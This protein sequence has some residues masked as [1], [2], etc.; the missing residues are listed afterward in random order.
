MP[1]CPRMAVGIR[2]PEEPSEE[3]CDSG[4]VRGEWHRHGRLGELRA[5]VPS[6][7]PALLAPVIGYAADFLASASPDTLRP[8]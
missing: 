1:S 7:F 5:V 4:Y 8:S 2:N 6:G 3:C